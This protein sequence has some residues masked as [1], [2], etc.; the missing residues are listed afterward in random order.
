MP[1]SRA[2]AVTNSR[3]LCC[4]PVAITKSSGAGCCSISHIAHVVP[5]VAPVAPRVE[6]CRRYRQSSSPT[7][8][9]AS[10]LVIFR[11][12][13]VSPRTGDSWLKRIPLQA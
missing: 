13:K 5:G 2:A 7:L 6:A 4:S 11:V 10:A 1:S 9:R 12:T 3:T 8:M